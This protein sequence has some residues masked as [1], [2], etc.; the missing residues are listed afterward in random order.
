MK[1]EDL[2]KFTGVF[3]GL[4]EYFD[5]KFSQALLDIYWNALRDWTIEQ[6]IEAANRAVRELKFFPKVSELRE[7]IHGDPSD[8]AERAWMQLLDAIR[9]YGHI[10]SVLFED[11][12]IARCVQAMGGWEQVCSWSIDETK[13]R[14]AEF[15]KLYRALPELPPER[16]VGTIESANTAA[17]YL[18]AGLQEAECNML[19]PTVVI[20]TDGT[21]LREL[22]KEDRGTEAVGNLSELKEVVKWV[23]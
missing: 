10:T 23:Q 9:L 12:R 1:P 18:K 22:P 2:E 14:H 3:V 15:T 17:G 20:K 5:K 6:F 8:Q 11:G 21:H 16:V 4:C 13:Y 19:C 7:L